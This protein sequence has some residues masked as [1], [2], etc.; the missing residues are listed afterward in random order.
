MNKIFDY[1]DNKIEFR[2]ANNIYFEE[3]IFKLYYCISNK[4]QMLPE[5]SWYIKTDNNFID[6]IKNKDNKRL[7]KK[8]I[9]NKEIK[10]DITNNVEDY[11]NFHEILSNNLKK[12]H[13]TTPTHTLK[14]FLLLKD[15][16]KDNQLLFVVKDKNNIIL[17]GTL[18]IKATNICWYTFYI[19]KNINYEG[20]YCS[21]VY[22][23][24]TAVNEAKKNNV[25]YID[26]GISTEDRGK[27]LNMG[28]SDYKENSLGGI[29]NSRFLFVSLK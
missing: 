21:I 28:L 13:N 6:N 22:L 29:S 3:S 25:K 15:I 19:S 4:K 5:L 2:I 17:G 1:Y 18:L 9:K 7:L 20:Q 27:E 24:Y 11:I 23:F 12:N 16:L 10:C 8:I 26:Y 14:E